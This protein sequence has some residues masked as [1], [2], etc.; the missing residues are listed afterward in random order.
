MALSTIDPEAIRAEARAEAAERLCNAC[1]MKINLPCWKSPSCPYRAS[2]LADEPKER[3]A[4][5]C[6]KCAERKGAPPCEFCG[7]P[8]WE[9]YQDNGDD[10][11]EDEESLQEYLDRMDGYGIDGECG[12][13]G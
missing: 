9:A 6:S 10:R 8:A 5:P 13:R 7:P 12:S 11:G 4:E 3:E 1:L 2:I